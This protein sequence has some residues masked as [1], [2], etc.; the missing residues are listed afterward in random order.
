MRKN[1]RKCSICVHNHVVAIKVCAECTPQHQ[2]F[3]PD[4]TKINADPFDYQMLEYIKK[5]FKEKNYTPTYEDI[6]NELKCSKSTV[7]VYML[8]LEK[9]GDIVFNPS[10][11]S[12]F[13]KHP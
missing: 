3:I 5:V 1:T 7:N 10:R 11:R 13:L 4:R 8:K 9:A 6:H 2:R 12:Y